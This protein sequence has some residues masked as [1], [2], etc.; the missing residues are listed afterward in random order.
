M[1]QPPI[2]EITPLNSKRRV[3]RAGQALVEGNASEEDLNVIENWRASHNHILNTFQ[4]NLR[5]RAKIS[6]ARTPVQRIKRLETIQ[7]KLLRFPEM[8]LARMHD[9]V[10]CRVVF[11]NVEELVAFRTQFNKSR[12]SHKRK[13]RIEGD[14]LLDA[15]NYI[16]FPKSSGYRGIHD[17]FKFRAKQGG[18]SKAAGGERWNGLNIEIQY[19]TKVQHAWATAVEI[20]D[21]YTENHGKFS[22]APHEYLLYFQIASELLARVFEDRTSCFPECNT[23]DLAAKFLELEE[24]HGMLLTLE[25]IQPHDENFPSE[26]NTLLIFDENIDEVEVRTFSSFKDAVQEYFMLERQLD[27]EKDIVLVAADDPESVRFGF[28]N[29]FSDARDFV[30]YMRRAYDP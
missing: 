26:R 11:E 8:Q 29:Y 5:R 27:S 23:G 24:K 4:A 10:G 1:Q 17:V 14:R 18:K 16:D 7:G 2:R 15:N 21:R 12:F 19:R 30:D 28:K 20:C 9:I 3:N 22:N 25:G 6:E 13:T